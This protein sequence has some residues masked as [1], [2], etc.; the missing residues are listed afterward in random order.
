L[1]RENL[2]TGQKGFFVFVPLEKRVE[3]KNF[4]L[5]AIFKK[6]ERERK[7]AESNPPRKGKKKIFF[8]YGRISMQREKGKKK[9][10]RGHLTSSIFSHRNKRR[11]KGN[12]N[13]T[14]WGEKEGKGVFFHSLST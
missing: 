1:K 12:E 11:E 5:E 13:E 3:K 6:C 4:L 8:G 9:K 14:I 7:R 10:E 2:G